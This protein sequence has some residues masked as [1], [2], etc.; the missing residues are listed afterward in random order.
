MP[1]S[2]LA[3]LTKSVPNHARHGTAR[4]RGYVLCSMRRPLSM[5]QLA[6]FVDARL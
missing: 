6:T 2:A 4:Q 5:G 3:L 1:F